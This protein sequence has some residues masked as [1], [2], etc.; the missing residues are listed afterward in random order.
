M[1]VKDRQIQLKFGWKVLVEHGL[2]DTGMVGYPS[3][4][5][6]TF[7]GLAVTTIFNP[8]L[9]IAGLVEIQSGLSLASGAD[10]NWSS[11]IWNV[12]DIC[13]V[14][15]SETPGGKWFTQF[16]AFP[17]GANAQQ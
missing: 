16:N 5:S 2:A 12:F 9:R 14:L 13:H 4:S 17:Q 10:M 7:Q 11:G 6:G 3:Y 1:E 15:E 8:L